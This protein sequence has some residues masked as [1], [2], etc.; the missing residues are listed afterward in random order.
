MEANLVIFNNE[1]SGIQIRNLEDKLEV[2][3]IDRTI[4]ILDIFAKRAKT[5]NGKLQVELAQQKYR[6][7][8][9]VGFGNYLTHQGA[10]I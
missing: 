10:G 3:V 6:K 8:R 4:L 2:K 5:K 1:L 9:L 7:S